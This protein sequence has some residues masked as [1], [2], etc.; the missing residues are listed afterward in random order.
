MVM[1]E[2]LV[3]IF[4][5]AYA[6]LHGRILVRVLKLRVMGSVCLFICT[7]HSLFPYLPIQCG[8]AAGAAAVMAYQKAVIVIS[9]MI[10]FAMAARAN[11]FAAD[12]RIE[13]VEAF[14][15]QDSAMK[16]HIEQS[17]SDVISHIGDTICII[18][19]I[20]G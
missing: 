11:T 1:D 17:V 2:R 10:P 14:L 15:L 9:A 4:A 7:V 19:L 8:L 13:E 20:N 6:G 16:T 18:F 12:H 5:G 3:N